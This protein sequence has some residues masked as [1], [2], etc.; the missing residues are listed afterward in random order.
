MSWT[1][2]QF[3]PSHKINNI[4]K[5]NWMTAANR[6]ELDLRRS[7]LLGPVVFTF[8]L[9]AMQKAG[10]IGL[11]VEIWNMSW[12]VEV[13]CRLQLWCLLVLAYRVKPY[14]EETKIL[15]AHFYG[16]EIDRSLPIYIDSLSTCKN[17]RMG[18]F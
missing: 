9:N 2:Y 1:Y 17:Q 5:T 11:D 14:A 4:V 8:F 7:I 6:H 15:T 13:N 3:L 12:T 10:N 18:F 16:K